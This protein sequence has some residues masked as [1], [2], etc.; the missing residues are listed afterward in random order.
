MKNTAAAKKYLREGLSKSDYY[1]GGEQISGTWEG[2]TAKLLGLSGQVVDPKVF[3]LLCDNLHPASFE[4]DSNG[5]P[6]TE[7]QQLTARNRD[8]RKPFYDFTFSAPKSVSILWATT[9]D[10]ALKAGIENAMRLA[11]SESMTVAEKQFALS[12][13]QRGSQTIY[14]QTGNI[15][16]TEFLH[17][18]TRPVGGQ[19]DPHLHIHVAVFN[20]TFDSSSEVN[21][22][23]S[24]EFHDF[25]K[26]RTYLEAIHHSKLA[27]FLQ[28]SVGLDLYNTHKS[29]E[30]AGFN[31]DLIDKFSNR[32][33]QV[34]QYSLDNEIHS[35][36]AKANIASIT[37]EHKGE[38]MTFEQL[39]ARWRDRFDTPTK[40]LID[41]SWVILSRVLRFGSSN[42][43][44]NTQI[45]LIQNSTTALESAITH[46]FENST[47]INQ[48]DLI[49]F[50]LNS[51]LVGTSFEG[52][53]KG[54]EGMKQENIQV[55]QT[56]SQVLSG[57][58]QIL[59]SK[60]I[61][62]TRS[63]KGKLE[64]VLT[65]PQIIAE[66]QRLVELIK[67]SKNNSR[68]LDTTYL[69]P[70][71]MSLDQ[72]K[73]LYQVL[74]SKD[75]INYIK[76]DAGAGKTYLLQNF[77][78]ALEGG[79]SNLG[80]KSELKRRTIHAFAPTSIAGRKILREEVTES[81]DT[82]AK[83]LMDNS[84]GQNPIQN[85][86]NSNSVVFIDEAGMIGYQQMIQLLELRQQKGYHLVLVGDTKQHSSMPRGDALRFLE[87]KADLIPFTLTDNRRQ[88][89]NPIY[90]AA[91]D[92]LAIRDIAGAFET[93]DQIGAV[94][95]IEQST[96]RYNAIAKDYIGLVKDSKN[97]SQARKEILVVTPTHEEAEIITGKIRAELKKVGVIGER[98][99]VTD[100]V[101]KDN[102]PNLN[103]NLNQ[104]KPELKP[105]ITYPALQDLKLTTTQ[106][107]L[108]NSYSKGQVLQ[109]NQ[110]VK[111]GYGIGS[112]WQVKLDKVSG[113]SVLTQLNPLKD[114]SEK[115]KNL[116]IPYTDAQAFSV[117]NP[118]ELKLTPGDLIKITT[119]STNNQGKKLLNGSSYTIKSISTDTQT[120][121]TQITLDNDWTLPKDFGHLSHGYT[122]TSYASQGRTVKHLIISQ[123]SVSMPASSYEQGYVS[124]SRGK[125]SI[126]WYTD[127]KKELVKALGRSKTREFAGHAVGQGVGSGLKS[128]GKVQPG[129]ESKAI[130]LP[131]RI[132]V[133]ELEI[134]L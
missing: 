106:K 86:L 91:V 7:H 105:D 10:T 17:D 76:G 116:P 88:K 81:A 77:K 90:K 100:K 58:N 32:T 80:G 55:K 43:T 121:Q 16:F 111:G 74:Q 65:T 68:G 85:A 24:M 61:A 89:D 98:E 62:T 83:L 127:D 2:E 45:S 8:D 5:V 72:D 128:K 48:H 123:S 41:G 110:N 27:G 133:K 53:N 15:L 4:L 21:S 37:R 47:V 29:F 124:A 11:V 104:P 130:N 44:R 30:I 119:N 93:L 102:D 9:K 56:E 87:Q 3:D 129:K 63:N 20:L 132:R 54:L 51:D 39:R 31:R 114:M 97:W 120:K 50:A 99:K 75:S 52:V 23:R 112:Q 134:G 118:I 49:S 107:A 26:F 96:N 35:A 109:F 69:L 46:H 25:A 33:L 94:K 113:Q 125:E 38:G 18:T 42:K 79:E 1:S 108:H 40:E 6:T 22:F 66:E 34:E 67:A 12:R 70:V 14:N 117:F 131:A 64:T 13:D 78:L 73:V 122:S 103:Q 57:T 92:Q 28:S 60:L 71:S 95:E 59:Q 126:S 115:L 36:K 19:P 84:K 82:V 101:Q